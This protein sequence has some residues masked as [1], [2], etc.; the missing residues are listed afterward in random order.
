MQD[1]MVFGIYGNTGDIGSRINTRYEGHVE[2]SG[3]LDV[4]IFRRYVEYLTYFG[5]DVNCL[6]LDVHFDVQAGK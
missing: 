6:G 5:L 1:M 3:S 2:Y 4:G